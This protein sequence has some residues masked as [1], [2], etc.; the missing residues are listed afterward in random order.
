MEDDG[1]RSDCTDVKLRKIRQQTRQ[2]EITARKDAA[3]VYHAHGKCNQI[4]DDKTCQHRKLLPVAFCKDIEQQAC[5]QRNRTEQQ[6]LRGT[7]ILRISSAE[8]TGSNGEK[9]ITDGGY[10]RRCHNRCDD[11]SPVLCQQTQ[12]SLDQAANQHR[13]HHRRVTVGCTYIAEDGHKGKADTHNDRQAETNLPDG[14]QLDEGRNACNEHRILQQ[15][16][17]LRMV[18]TGGCSNQGNRSQVCHKHGKD[19]LKPEGDCLE[20]RHLSIKLI[21]ILCGCRCLFE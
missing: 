5:H 12:C 9:G 1:D 3:E 2:R 19:V 16:C 10:H 15:D 4:T 6:V 7:K 8:G 13:S 14:I 11:F 21:D 18:Q 20:E 17:N